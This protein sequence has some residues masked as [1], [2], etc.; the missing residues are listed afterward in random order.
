MKDI[1]DIRS[2]S[3]EFRFEGGPLS[4]AIANTFKRRGTKL[5]DGKALVFTAEFFANHDK[6][7]QWAAFCAKNKSYIEGIPLKKVC[8]EID[9]FL[10]P[11]LQVVIGNLQPPLTW[12]QEKGWS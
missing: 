12:T 3:R 11:I 2:L 4:D 6:E 1:Y 9:A 7:K 8:E 5:P 10:S